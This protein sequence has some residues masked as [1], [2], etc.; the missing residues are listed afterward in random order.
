[1]KINSLIEHLENLKEKYG[2]FE[3]FVSKIKIDVVKHTVEL[4]S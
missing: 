4:S 2:D 3:T 1:M